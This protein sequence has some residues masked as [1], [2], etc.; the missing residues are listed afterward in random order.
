ASRG[1]AGTAFLEVARRHGHL[2]L[3]AV[4]AAVERDGDTVRRARLAFAGVGSVA[5]RADEA[6][7]SL[8]G[9]AADEATLTAA[10][11]RAAAELDPRSAHHGSAGYR[12]HVAGVLAGRALMLAAARAR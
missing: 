6:E 3:A 12:R 4:A 8:A 10:G 2:A 5:I 1:R 9:A 11:V 7:A